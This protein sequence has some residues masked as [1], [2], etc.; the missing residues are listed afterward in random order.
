MTWLQSRDFTTIEYEQFQSNNIHT[1]WLS[2]VYF[3]V[4]S[5]PHIYADILS[6]YF[7]SI[8]FPCLISFYF[9]T[10]RSTTVSSRYLN[11]TLHGKMCLWLEDTVTFVLCV[12][13]MG[14]QI[15]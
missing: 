11:F 14:A 1:H 10:N 15:V 2:S 3:Y 7:L 8:S 6:K 13:M 9:G 5:A 4:I 12:V